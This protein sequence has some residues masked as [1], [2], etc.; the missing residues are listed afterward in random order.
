VLDRRWDEAIQKLRPYAL[1][2]AR[3]LPGRVA[4]AIN[5]IEQDGVS[6]STKFWGVGQQNLDNN[7]ILFPLRRLH[8]IAR[9]W[10]QS[11]ERNTSEARDSRVRAILFDAGVLKQ[12]AFIFRSQW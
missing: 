6:G 10:L 11:L 4:M 9:S 8:D 1:K 7:F 5:E 3:E 12:K 2:L